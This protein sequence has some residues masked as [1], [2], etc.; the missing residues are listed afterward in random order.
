MQ[1][2]IAERTASVSERTVMFAS[3]L[4]E[5]ASHAF[6]L[7]YAHPCWSAT[8]ALPMNS[9][10]ERRCA[11]ILAGFQV[12]MARKGLTVEV[13]KPLYDRSRYYLGREEADVVVKPDFEGKVLAADGRFIRTFVIEVMGYSH[14][15]YLERSQ[16]D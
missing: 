7:A 11:D 8:D 2:I 13:T 1:F 15:I 10:H 14:R 9:T 6:A 3:W 4:A 12:W 5:P 16:P